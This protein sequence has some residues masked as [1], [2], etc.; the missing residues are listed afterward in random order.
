MHHS[1]NNTWMHTHGD[2]SRHIFNIDNGLFWGLMILFSETTF[3]YGNTACDYT[4]SIVN[5][6]YK[7]KVVSIVLSILAV[8]TLVNTLVYVVTLIGGFKSIAEHKQ[9]EMFHN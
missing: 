5:D 6:W 4:K 3:N 7:D 8:H 2:Q 1:N 9:Y